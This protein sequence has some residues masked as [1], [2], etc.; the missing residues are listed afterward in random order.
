MAADLNHQLK[1]HFEV[2]KEALR[3]N[4][5]IDEFIIYVGAKERDGITQTQ[6]TLIWEIYKRNLPMKV[7]IIPT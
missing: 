6:S 7:E 3:Q 1:G 4:P 5:S 2:V